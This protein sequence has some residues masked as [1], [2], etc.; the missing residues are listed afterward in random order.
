[1]ETEIELKF[2][3]SPE[4][5]DTLFEKMSKAK[6]LQHSLRTVSYTTLTLPTK[7]EG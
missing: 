7:K 5:S 6:V 4:F 1:M 3:V 2:F